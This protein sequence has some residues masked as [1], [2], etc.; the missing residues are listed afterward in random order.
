MKKRIIVL[1]SIL[2]MNPSYAQKRGIINNAES[3]YVKLKSINIGDWQS[4]GR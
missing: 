3:P 4:A 2:M 1:C